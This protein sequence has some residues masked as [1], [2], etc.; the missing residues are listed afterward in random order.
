MCF[1]AVPTGRNEGELLGCDPEEIFV[2]L[3]SNMALLCFTA[4]V[5]FC[6][7]L[8]SFPHT[9]QIYLWLWRHFPVQ[10]RFWQLFLSF[11]Q[12]RLNKKRAEIFGHTLVKWVDVHSWKDVQSW[13]P[14]QGLAELE[15]RI[16]KAV[17]RFF[18]SSNLTIHVITSFEERKRTMLIG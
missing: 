8:H 4:T 1:S 9:L 10:M 6:I 7:A 14:D 5:R 17:R 15:G 2:P 11:G 16:E 12:N 18:S 3:P 13:Q